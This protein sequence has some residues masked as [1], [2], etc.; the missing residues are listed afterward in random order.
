M[1]YWKQFLS[2]TVNPDNKFFSYFG[3]KV[4]FLHEN[5]PKSYQLI[6]QYNSHVKRKLIY[7]MGE[8]VV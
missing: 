5:T 4:I 1:V 3:V 2:N 8:V 7:R 6:K